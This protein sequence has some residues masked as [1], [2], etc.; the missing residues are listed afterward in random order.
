MAAT[1]ARH[2]PAPPGA[3]RA[4]LRRPPA[5]GRGRGRGI[6]LGGISLP[7]SLPRLPELDQRQRDVIGLALAA[8]GVLAGSVIHGGGDGGR[9]GHWLAVG[10]GLAIG[11][12]RELAPVALIVAGG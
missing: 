1:R 11:G 10:L 2:T 8:L 3:R 5:A 12:A 4:A 7:T 9:V 6:G